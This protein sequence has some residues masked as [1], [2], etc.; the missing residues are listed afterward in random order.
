M[1]GTK[2]Q[3]P[4]SRRADPAKRDRDRDAGSILRGRG[5]ALRDPRYVM[6]P[7]LLS[8]LHRFVL[9]YW[10]RHWLKLALLV[11]IVA[12]GAGSFLS[13]GLA[14]RAA[15][16]SF[17]T[18]AQAVSGRSQITITASAGS[19]SLADVQATRIS[20][21]DT[22]ATLVPQLVANARLADPNTA[23]AGNANFTL[24]GIDLLAA[25][26]FL[27]RQNASSTFIAD[28]D[29][30]APNELETPQFYSEAS[31]AKRFG[32]DA[33]SVAS[34]VIADQIQELAWRAPLPRV[35]E[36]PET[37][38]RVLVIDWQSLARLVQR[39][40]Q[41]DRIDIV[42]PDQP[43]RSAKTAQAI[44]LLEASNPGHWIVETQ[45]QRQKTGAT[46]TQALRMNL[47]ALSALSFL[48]AIC[49]VF[50]AMDSAIA[51]RQGEVATLH[52]IGVSTRLTRLLWLAD[53]A[54]IGTVGG[55]AGVALG[56]VMAQ[57]STALV[58]ETVDALYHRSANA[59]V[60]LDGSEI[61]IAW[62]LSIL[63]CLAAGWWPARQAAKAPL[64]ETMRKGAN[65]S[66]YSRTTYVI[67]SL[68]LSLLA[69]SCL[70][71][72]PLPAA[73]GHGIPLG[74]YALAL[75]LIGA[76]ATLACLL[77]EGLGLV[78]NRLGR[79]TASLRVALSQFRK[80]V[81]RHRLALAGVTISVGMTAA[82]VLMIGSFESTV[83]AWIG[84]ALGADIYIQSRASAS[85]RERAAIDPKT[86]AAILQRPGIEDSGTILSSPLRIETLSTSL[87]GLDTGYLQRHD[88]TTWLQA[89][90]SIRGLADSPTAIVNE[91]FS[92]RFDKAV[93]DT[94]RFNSPTGSVA[95]TVIGIFADYGNEGGSI[96][97]D[98]AR[99]RQI[100]GQDAPIGLALHLKD[101]NQ[102][103]LMTR[104]L[105]GEYPGLKVMTNRL[106]REESLRL[107]K[108]VFSI[109]Y[110]LEVLGLSIA[111]A[112][113][114]SML[115]SLLI[116]RRNEIG[117]L[118]RIGLS[119]RQL[120][121]TTLVEGLSLATLGTL[122]GLLLGSLL[123]L[124][125]VF[126]INRQSFGWTLQLDIPWL[127]LA[128]LATLTLA[129]A[130]ITSWLVGRWASNLP[131][132][133]EE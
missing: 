94:I 1:T 47:R 15:T 52:S 56:S 66:S 7:L 29:Q 104:E 48:V 113:L 93:G 68:L 35:E 114:G 123:G 25:S 50:Q 36:N 133:N 8:L 121:K 116:E 5:P 112:G 110:A 67:A 96:G 89:P 26:N 30:P 86:I 27:L 24:I 105:S 43:D 58:S 55:A 88:H 46:M 109:T 85:M 14:N 75:M 21:L 82:M 77:L 42:L 37:E 31:T 12:L 13:I 23:D 57:F 78:A 117:A 33:E 69:L 65:R 60:H 64:V 124:V 101:P 3:T 127:Q 111:I 49:L 100:T 22:E 62:T 128:M 4:A 83:R 71:I 91:T 53:A 90:E 32:W 54:F 74:G 41:A 108:R 130:A 61:A 70:Y 39:P 80:P 73:N 34:F 2:P 81:T 131:V 99:Y 87:I 125:L 51:R 59:G 97:V 107:F 92:Q 72:P 126:I 132:Q 63:A 95:L 20:L 122:A 115:A 28:F 45:D 119:P 18:F 129:G 118:I 103:D 40:N 11:G 16:N 76:I 106:L 79:K 120:A 38:S 19:L 10:I 6:N 98:Q 9:R 102:V 44:Q 17:D 84:N